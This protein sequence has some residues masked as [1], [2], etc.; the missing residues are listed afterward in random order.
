MSKLQY[1]KC[2]ESESNNDMLESVKINSA[3]L[4]SNQVLCLLLY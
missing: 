1:N 3:I 2:I 4:I